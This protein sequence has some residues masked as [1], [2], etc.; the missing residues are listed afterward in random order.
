MLFR[1]KLNRHYIGIE[2]EPGYIEVARKR[3]AAVQPIS[4][5][6]AVLVTP[7][8]R[9]KPRV[10]FSQILDTQYLS[11]GQ[12]VF[13]ADRSQR[14]LVMAD[15]MLRLGDATGSIHTIAALAAGKTAQNGWEY[16]YYEELD[17]RLTSI[18]ALR[19]RYR[20]EAML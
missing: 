17:G 2:R 7:T 1:S 12:T 14:A 16:W 5:G 3:I 8:A 13:S 10:R 4:G 20:K 6:D 19:E 9:N 18:D 11:A 15:S